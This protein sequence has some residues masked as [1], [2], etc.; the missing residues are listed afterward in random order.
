MALALRERGGRERARAS[1]PAS[2]REMRICVYVVM[3]LAPW[4]A[5]SFLLV[6]RY[7]LSPVRTL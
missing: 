1:G 2:Q 3:A 6:W 4:L 7:Y 5:V